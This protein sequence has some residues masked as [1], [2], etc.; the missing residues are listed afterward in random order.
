MSFIK[1]AN[2]AFE[3]GNYAAAV[4]LYQQAISLQPQLAKLYQF[5]LDRAR[6]RMGFALASANGPIASR[7][8]VAE[9]M[10]IRV[11]GQIDLADLYSEVAQALPSLASP[12]VGTELPLVSV[13]MTAHNVQPYIEAAVLSVLNQTYP[14]LELVVVDDNSTDDTWPILTRL[15]KSTGRVRIKRLNANLGTYFA[16]NFGIGQ[17]RGQFVF[18]Q[19]GDD[20]CHPERISLCMAQFTGADVLAVNCCYSRVLFPQGQ[21]LPINGSV[22]KEG[23][24]T[25]GYRRAVFDDIG[26][27]NCTTKA[28][29]D[30]FYRRLQVWLRTKGGRVAV[31]GLP[32]YYNTLRDGSLFADMVANNPAVDGTIEQTLSPARAAYVQTFS[33][34]HQKLGADGLADFFKF[35][36]TRD[37]MPVAPDMTR[38]ANPALPVVLCLCSIPERVNLLRQTLASLAPQVDEI[39]IYLD[40]YDAVPDFVQACRVQ[41]TVVRSQDHPGLRDNGKFLPFAELRHPCYYFTADDDIVYPPDYVNAMVQKIEWYGRQAVVGVHGVLLPDQPRGY[42]SGFRQVYLFTK[43]LERDALVSNLGTGTV[44]FYSGTLQ[45]LDYRAFTHSGMAD[46]YLSVF[47]KQQGIPMVA[48]ARPDNWLQEMGT[49]ANTLYE[50]FLNAD[51]RQVGLIGANLP[52]GYTAIKGAVEALADHHGQVYASKRLAALLPVLHPCL[53]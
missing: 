51:E 24:I 53:A 38:L 44:A 13:I 39:H 3:A 19:D 52:W 5:S 7:L 43:A 46:I 33:A 28:S 30:E 23:R 49:K 20:L 11:P 50:E 22:K 25:L 18:F 32:L 27:F 15:A 1:R 29:D 47:C 35:P 17:A 8:T 45:G 2:A 42:F 31:L 41:V 21:V 36:V 4:N 12:M 16:K 26:F 10:R 14:A 34:L 48:V 37:L 40:R 9:P 6:A